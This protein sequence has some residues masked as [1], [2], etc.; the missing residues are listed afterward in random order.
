MRKD[1]HR[2]VFLNL[3]RERQGGLGEAKRGFASIFCALDILKI[4]CLPNCA[5]GDVRHVSMLDQLFECL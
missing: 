1:R 2:K 5:T 3:T 4:H